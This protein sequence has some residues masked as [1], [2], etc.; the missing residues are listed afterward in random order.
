[1]R[2]STL[3]LMALAAGLLSG[4]AT[5]GK[6]LDGTFQKPTAEF[7][8]MKLRDIN[9]EKV[10][11]DFEFLVTNPNSVSVD[12]ASLAYDLRFE[13]KQLASGNTAK[14]LKLEARGTAPVELPLTVT[15][16][17][18]VDNLGLLFSS[19]E[20]VPYA[21][22][23]NFGF[24]TFAGEVK[25][26]V[27]QEGEVPLPKVPEVSVADVR[28]SNVSLTGARIEVALDVANKGQFPIQPR[29]LQYNLAVAGT[30][31]ASA[32]QSLPVLAA[33]AKQQL[34]LPVDLSFLKLGS[35]VVNA[36]RSKSLPWS[37]Q[38][39]IDLGLFQQP[40]SVGGTAKL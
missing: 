12:L 18:F 32:Q 22:D 24:N 34:V 31:V 11:M 38:G 26:P 14:P 28:M 36:V 20:V 15:F 29:G 30:S 9:F 4:C 17:D 8:Q 7:R 27:H 16:K 33:G 6:I 1:M 2:F 40:F 21:V 10:T 13:N 19:K 25:I 5:V 23:L 35:A 37:M 39:N 3:P